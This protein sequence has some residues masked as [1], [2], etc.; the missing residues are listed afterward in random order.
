MFFRNCCFIHLSCRSYLLASVDSSRW[1]QRSS[2]IHHVYAFRNLRSL[3][4]CRGQSTRGWADVPLCRTYIKQKSMWNPG[5]SI[6][7]QIGKW[8]WRDK[9]VE[10]PFSQIT[11]KF[12]ETSLI[13]FISSYHIILQVEGALRCMY[14]TCTSY[15]KHT[16]WMWQAK[17]WRE[18]AKSISTHGLKTEFT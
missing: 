14:C 5:L 17:S 3:C 8:V 4:S 9:V 15:N 11:R 13:G 6:Q 2:Y 7:S 18:V 10:S 1:F 16:E 12:V